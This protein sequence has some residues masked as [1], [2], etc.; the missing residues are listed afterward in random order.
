MPFATSLAI[1]Q[2][3]RLDT[4]ANQNAMR[5]HGRISYDDEFGGVVRTT[6]KAIGFAVR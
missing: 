4:L 3:G 5:F 2:H 1:R 6:P